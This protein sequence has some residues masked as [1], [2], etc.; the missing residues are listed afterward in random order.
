M[1]NKITR[2]N[3]PTVYTPY[4]NVYT[5]VIEA[6]G[7]NHVHVA[8]TVSLD[9]NRNL[10]GEGDM[11]VQT[12]TV[13]ENLRL[14]LEA[15]GATPADVVRINIFTTDVDR[16]LAEGIASMAAFFGETSPTSTLAGI[17]R[18]ADPRY[19]VEIECDALVSSND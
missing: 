9:V 17:V 6:K 10:V 4:N 2:I 14:S 16:F 12:A 19:L 5:Q 15:A 8:G 13:F 11:A 7:Q 1:S 3:P 18:L